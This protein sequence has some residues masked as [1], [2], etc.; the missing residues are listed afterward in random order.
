[1]V[2][3]CNRLFS[4]LP[5]LNDALVSL[6]APPLSGFYYAVSPHNIPE[7]NWIVGFFAEI[8]CDDYYDYCETAKTRFIGYSSY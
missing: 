8:I 4:V 2:H 3:F 5:K 1:M 7:A 6:E